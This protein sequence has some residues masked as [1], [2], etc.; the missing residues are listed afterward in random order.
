MRLVRPGISGDRV[1]IGIDMDKEDCGWSILCSNG[2][3]MAGT[4]NDIGSTDTIGWVLKEQRFGEEG[5]QFVLLPRD[6]YI[7]QHTL[8]QIDNF[9]LFNDHCSSSPPLASASL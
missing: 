6:Y 8:I 9:F 7:G 5:Y 2:F 4:G 3:W 1:D